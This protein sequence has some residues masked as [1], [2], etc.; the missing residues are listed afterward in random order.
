M[1]A[2]LMMLVLNAG[3]LHVDH[4]DRSAAGRLAGRCCRTPGRTLLPDAWPDAAAGRLAGRCCRT[5]WIPG[6]MALERTGSGVS[7]RSSWPGAPDGDADGASV[8]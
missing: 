2:A 5:H 7:W 3:Q 8:S 1:D 4:D 6:F